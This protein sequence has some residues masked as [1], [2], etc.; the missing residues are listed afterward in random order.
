MRYV[1]YALAATLIGLT[2]LNNTSDGRKILRQ[3]DAVGERNSQAYMP[4]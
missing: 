4:D 1:F 2:W 3:M